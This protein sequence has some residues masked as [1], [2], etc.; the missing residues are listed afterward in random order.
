VLCHGGFRYGS[1]TT[2]RR[3]A[4]CWVQVPGQRMVDW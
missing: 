2:R 1:Q 3:R 4:G